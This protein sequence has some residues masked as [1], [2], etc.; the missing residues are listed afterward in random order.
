MFAELC[1]RSRGIRRAPLA[2]DVR[3]S[4][5][6]QD[7]SAALPDLEKNHMAYEILFLEASD[8][9]LVRRF[10]ETRRPHSLAKEYGIL[11]AIQVEQ[12]NLQE[13]RNKAQNILDTTGLGPRNLKEDIAEIY[14]SDEGRGRVIITVIALGCKQDLPR[15]NTRDAYPVLDVRRKGAR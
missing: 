4:Q 11:E 5:F 12:G 3:G 9:V 10:K 14:R 13:L 6:F 2:I 15:V 1:A 8:D 7:L